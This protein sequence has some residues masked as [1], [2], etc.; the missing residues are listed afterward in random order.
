MDILLHV[1]HVLAAIGL[2]GLVLIQHGKGADAGASFGG[3]A[4][5][6]FFGSAGAA[7]F[8]TRS[9]AILAAVFMLTSLA[10]AWQARQLVNADA[11][12]LPALEK[13]Q[14]EVPELDAGV[15]VIEESAADV[16]QVDVESPASDVPVVE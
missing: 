5:N 16:P 12:L 3:G 7:N 11:D 10:L 1:V 15:P 4:S 14:Q 13:I 8:L 9:T 2:I 6:S